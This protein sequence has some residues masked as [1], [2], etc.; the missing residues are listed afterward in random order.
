MAAVV[1]QEPVMFAG[2]LRKNLDPA[3]AKRAD[4]LMA[5]LE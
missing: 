1:P 4:E 5:A 3:G 2:A